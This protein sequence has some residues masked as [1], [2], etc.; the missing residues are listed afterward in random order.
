MSDTETWLKFVASMTKIF[1]E[2]VEKRKAR[3]SNDEP[4]S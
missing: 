4:D 2:F 3:R 1:L